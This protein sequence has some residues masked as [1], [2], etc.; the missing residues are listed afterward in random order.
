MPKR[1]VR[2]LVSS[3]LGSLYSM[4]LI[5]LS[6]GIEDLIELLGRHFVVEVVI[7]LQ[8]RRPGTGAD[9]FHFF[10]RDAAVGGDLFMADTH[11][12][13]GLLPEFGASVEQATDV[14]ADLD[15]RFPQRLAVQH[16][17]VAE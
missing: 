14:G 15:V 6:A 16:G 1:R 5:R 17:V 7:D 3:G 4:W 12:V 13:A 10:E 9:A 2:T 11:L 8:G